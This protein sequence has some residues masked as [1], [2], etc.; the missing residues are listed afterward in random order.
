MRNFRI[1]HWLCITAFWAVALSSPSTARESPVDYLEWQLPVDQYSSV[2]VR[3]RAGSPNTIQGTKKQEIK[4]LP[5]TGKVTLS[6]QKGQ[7]F[8]LCTQE[9]RTEG[10]AQLASGAVLLTTSG[11][12]MPASAFMLSLTETTGRLIIVD[13]QPCPAHFGRQYPFVSQQH[14][15]SEKPFLVM[16]KRADR[17]QDHPDGGSLAPF[18]LAIKPQPL[19]SL[20]GG[21]YGTDD[22]NDFKRPPFMP[23]QD[24][25][26]A[27]LILLPTLSLPANWRDYLPFAGLYHWL[28]TTGHEGVTIIIRFGHQSPITLRISQAES[29]EL[30]GQLLNL[31][32]L[33]HW[34]APRLNGRESLIQQ[35]LELSPA[36]NDT[37][38]SEKTLNAIRR[39]LAIVLEQPDTDFSLEFEYSELLRTLTGQDTKQQPPG[40]HQLGGTQ[41]K[42]TQ[43]QATGQ[44]AGGQRSSTRPAG[45]PG[46]ENSQRQGNRLYPDLDPEGIEPINGAYPDTPQYYTIKVHQ[47]LYRINSQQVLS[48]LNDKVSEAPLRLECQDC[49]QTG[50]PLRDILPHAESHHLVC[51]QCQQFKPGAGPYDVR[52]RMLECHTQS[53]CQRYRGQEAA[54]PLTDESLPV[55]RFMLR[56]GTEDTLLNLLRQLTLPMPAV[57]LQQADQYGRTLLHDLTQHTP[58]SVI[59]TA[60]QYFRQKVT[61]EHLQA[62]DKYGWTPLHHLFQSQS[63]TFIL[64]LIQQLDKRITPRLL[65]L[66][67]HRGS[68]LPHVLYH[69]GFSRAITEILKHVS[70]QTGDALKQELLVLQDISGMSLLH[71]VFSG[72]DQRVVYD[73]IDQWNRLFSAEA[74]A[75][76][77]FA[78]ETPLH[79][80]FENGAGSGINLLID[81]CAMH[82]HSEL[83]SQR[84]TSDGNTPLH[85]LFARREPA[86]IKNLLDS[87]Y[88]HID[89]AVITTPN[90]ADISVLQAL[91]Q[92]SQPAS[93]FAWLHQGSLE[94]KQGL[95]TILDGSPAIGWP[96]FLRGAMAID[97][98]TPQLHW[99]RGELERMGL[100]EPSVEPSAPPFEQLASLNSEPVPS[101][102]T[103]SLLNSAAAEKVERPKTPAA[104]IPP[105][106]LKITEKSMLTDASGENLLHGIARDCSAEEIADIFSRNSHTITPDMLSA[107]NHAG[108]TPLH[109]LM[110]R[111]IK[112]GTVFPWLVNGLSY[113]V[114]NELIDQGL[115]DKYSWQQ[116]YDYARLSPYVEKD[117]KLKQ[118]LELMELIFIEAP[119]PSGAKALTEPLSTGIAAGAIAYMECPI[120]SDSMEDNCALTPCCDQIFHRECIERWVGANKNPCS[121]CRGYLDIKLLRNVRAPLIVV[122]GRNEPEV[123]D[124]RPKVKPEENSPLP[125]G[126]GTK[127][128]DWLYGAGH[129]D[130]SLR[131]P[132]GSAKQKSPIR[133]RK[134]SALQQAD[135]AGTAT[136][137]IDPTDYNRLRRAASDGDTAT[138]LACI[139]AGMRLDVKDTDGN[140]LLHLAAM[141]GHMGDG[142]ETS[143]IRNCTE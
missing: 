61:P 53:Q 121:H 7:L 80:L 1:T 98:M 45:R 103:E 4:E 16:G 31:R 66:Q 88:L 119:E 71:I 82:L 95:K 9:L 52:S 96:D 15:Q 86:L 78:G 3:V 136:Y 79:I 117:Q 13:S 97:V 39:Q 138:V 23:A 72:R 73:F 33:L 22:H 99:V 8:I 140:T 43:S 81:H 93:A 85:L 90:Y 48:H 92:H 143:S 62:Q 17:V 42:T 55:L 19:P 60:V 21:G 106:A 74:L 108:F 54:A 37:I 6:G 84:R 65:T 124:V 139:K 38:L 104:S 12:D 105:Q 91:L 113:A 56:F 50:I 126:D 26:M 11:S 111:N 58:A 77:T 134:S 122:E 5:F 114:A 107:A 112:P 51:E 49:W 47:T 18:G 25:L 28:T 100:I 115:L 127:G 59:K 132:G 129:K 67:N 101:A 35:L 63:E 70:S 34:L 131:E 102:P 87:R 36:E 116:L 128:S 68:T 64:E 44:G 57:D 10:F 20:S 14:I 27:D 24:K 141:N 32:Q 46:S 76:E 30:A 137:D 118:I 94:H 123:I 120:C 69:R 41:S 109:I 89:Q 83:L 75:V 135:S 29:R 125:S 133:G 142:Y 110:D 2:S 130:D 40:I